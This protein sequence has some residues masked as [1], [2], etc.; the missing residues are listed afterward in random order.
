[1]THLRPLDRMICHPKQGLFENEEDT[2]ML[3]VRIFTVKDP[4]EVGKLA[5]D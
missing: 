2:K 1:M 5:A 4:T 3:H